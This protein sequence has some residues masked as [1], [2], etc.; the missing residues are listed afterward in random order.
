MLNRRISSRRSNAGFSMIEVMVAMTISLLLF[1]GLLN[2]YVSTISSSTQLM[3]TAHL[4]NELHKMLD[5]MARDIRRA[6]THGN[7]QVLVTGVANPFGVEGT[8]AYT[9]E[10]ANSCLVFS[11]DWDS[12]GVLDTSGQDERYGFRLKQGVVQS[13]V[14]GLGCD[15]DGTPN[16]ENVTDPRSYNITSLQF[17]PT[18]VSADDMSIR[19]VR[20]TMA[21]ELVSDTS[22]VRSLSKTVRVRNDLRNP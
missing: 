3:T 9:G 4:D 15:A 16:W 19:S 1:G 22:V 18:T 14:S 21:A 13:R 8:G 12:D 5:M 17:A 6:G 11:Y 2:A 20:I 10:T 7:P